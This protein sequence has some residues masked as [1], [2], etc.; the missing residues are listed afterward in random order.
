MEI[1]LI[2]IGGS[3]YAIIPSEFIKVYEL[4]KYLYYCEVSP[5]GKTITYKRMRE[6]ENYV[7]PELQK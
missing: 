1:K 6:D 7:P 5:D 4:T 2:K 3:H